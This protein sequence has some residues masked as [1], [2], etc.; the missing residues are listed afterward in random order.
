MWR[1]VMLPTRPGNN[2]GPG[3]APQQQPVIYQSLMKMNTIPQLL[4]FL[5]KIRHEDLNIYCKYIGWLAN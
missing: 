4:H 5:S 2:S 3:S 1:K